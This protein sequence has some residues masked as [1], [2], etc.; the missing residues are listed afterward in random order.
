MIQSGPLLFW[1]H[2]CLLACWPGLAL[3]GALLGE[4]GTKGQGKFAAP[5]A[6]LTPLA[7]PLAHAMP[8]LVAASALLLFRPGGWWPDMSGRVWATGLAAC[9]VWLLLHLPRLGRAPLARLLRPAPMALLAGFFLALGLL[10]LANATPL[11]PAQAGHATFLG[12]GIAVG[13][14]ATPNLA[15]PSLATPGRWLA[16]APLLLAAVA[17]A[18]NA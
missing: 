11:P 3:A 2:L 13:S 5:A 4:V 6:F 16:L 14:L 15:T 17:C 9:L 12:L 10:S 1:L 7:T 18:L 8:A